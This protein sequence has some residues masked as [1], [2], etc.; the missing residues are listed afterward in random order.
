MASEGSIEGSRGHHEVTDVDPSAPPTWEI[1]IVDGSAR[2]ALE[3]VG[4]PFEGAEDAVHAGA[5]M[6]PASPEQK[7]ARLPLLK[8]RHR[9]LLA[10]R[11]AARAEQDE[12]D[13]LAADPTDENETVDA[14]R[15][16]FLR[17]LDQGGRAVNAEEH[18]EGMIDDSEISIR[19][20]NIEGT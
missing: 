7:A 3:R 12:L 1:V 10:E 17:G 14:E 4:E 5:T 16:R 13:A 6:K 11:A 18:R 9:A 15:R 2:R 19:D 20:A 8:S